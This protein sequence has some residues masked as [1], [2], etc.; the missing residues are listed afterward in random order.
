M[1]LLLMCMYA[2]S[3]CPFCCGNLIEQTV[4]CGFLVLCYCLGEGQELISLVFD[5]TS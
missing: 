5:G 2:Y 4:Q 3:I 1:V